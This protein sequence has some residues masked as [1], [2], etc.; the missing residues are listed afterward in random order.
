MITLAGRTV[1]VV[2]AGSSRQGTSNGKAACLTYARAGAE[3]AA[4][5]LDREALQV[6]VDAVRAEGGSCLAIEADAAVEADSARAAAAA[7]AAYGRIDVLHNNVGLLRLGGPEALALADWDLTMA[8]NLRGAFLAC[9]HVL[10]LMKRQ[11]GGAVVNVSSIAGGRW[12]GRPMLAYSA[13]KAA[14]DQLTRSVAV[15]YA[16]YG[17]RCNAVVPGLIDTPMV[18]EPY[19]AVYGDEARLIA[20]R[21]ALCPPGRMGTPWEVA[22]AALFLAS[23]LA[24]YVNGALLPVDGGLSCKAF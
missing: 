1:L 15:E 12:C 7:Q 3:V 21:A 10:P 11:G 23:D 18:R 19:A 6:T 14:L 4:V 24:G 20:E 22:Q 5:D 16:P 17:I 2:G 9:R 13:S 8:A